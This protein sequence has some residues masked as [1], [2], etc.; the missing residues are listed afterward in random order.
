MS[1]EKNGD[2]GCTVDCTGIQAVGR[3]TRF[4]V[5]EPVRLGARVA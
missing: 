1:L 2:S 5:L 3:A 4:E